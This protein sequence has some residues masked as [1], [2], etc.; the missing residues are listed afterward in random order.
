[1]LLL[2]LSNKCHLGEHKRLVSKTN[3]QKSYKT[4]GF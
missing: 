1:M 3:K 2:Y 4:P